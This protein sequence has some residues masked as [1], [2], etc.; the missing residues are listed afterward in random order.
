MKK[1]IIGI[2]SA[3]EEEKELKNYH[4]TTVCIDYAKS[5]AD[6]GGIPLVIPVLEDREII[7]SQLELVDGLL[8]S[9]GLDINP[10]YYNQDFLGGINLISPERDRNEWTILEEYLSTGKPLL[11]VCRGMQMINIFL[12]GTLYQDMRHIS[13]TLLNHRQNYLPELEVHRVEI[14]ENSILDNL[15]GREL[16]T[17]SF[18]HQ[19]VDKL[20]RDLKVTGTT[21]DNI[22]EAFEGVRDG[23]LLGVQWHPEMMTARGNKNMLKI[24]EKFVQESKK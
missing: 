22:I 19:A 13:G 21:S 15:F 6:A 2:T 14:A 7:K 8:M 23:F 18:H 1:P 3:Y 17:N 20:G 10:Q 5:I 16:L 9:G 11:G 4:R 12:G 24:F